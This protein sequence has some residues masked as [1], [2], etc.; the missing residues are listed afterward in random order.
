[1]AETAVR[2][3][4]PRL[5]FEAVV[6]LYEKSSYTRIHTDMFSFLTCTVIPA[7]FENPLS[8]CGSFD[9]LVFSL[10][11]FGEATRE[12]QEIIAKVAS[13]PFPEDL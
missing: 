6:I 4:I 10:D 13:R 11:S 9:L 8:T 3:V 2:L 12:S 1:M 7:K 5:V